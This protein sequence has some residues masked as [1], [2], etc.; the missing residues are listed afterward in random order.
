M[1]VRK[2]KR[3]GMKYGLEDEWKIVKDCKL[4]KPGLID[5]KIREANGEEINGKI[6]GKETFILC[7][8]WIPKYVWKKSI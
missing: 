7:G 6:N 4:K 5:W 3:K 1:G 2:P 8:F